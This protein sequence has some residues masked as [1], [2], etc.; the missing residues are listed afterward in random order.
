[1][2]LDVPFPAHSASLLVKDLE[3]TSELEGL[4]VSK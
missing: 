4:G 1:M 2:L 3:P